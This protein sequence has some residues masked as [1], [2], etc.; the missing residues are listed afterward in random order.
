MALN[1]KIGKRK[2]LVK[3]EPELNTTA[4]TIRAFETGSQEG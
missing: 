1:D 4:I 2:I 3:E